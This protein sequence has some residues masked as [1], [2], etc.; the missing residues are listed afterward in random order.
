MILLPSIPPRTDLFGICLRFTGPLTPPSFYLL[1][2][3]EILDLFT[4]VTVVFLFP[5]LSFCFPDN[6][7]THG[8]MCEKYTLVDFIYYKQSVK[9]NILSKKKS[10]K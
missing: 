3:G 7:N 4:V 8:I 9:G 10:C 1:K 2:D 6:E 5:Q